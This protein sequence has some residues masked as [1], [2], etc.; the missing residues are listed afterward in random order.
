MK[1]VSEKCMHPNPIRGDVKIQLLAAVNHCKI[2]SFTKKKSQ[3]LKMFFLTQYQILII[4]GRLFKMLVHPYQQPF[5][6]ACKLS[7]HIFMSP[8]DRVKRFVPL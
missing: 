7:P 2:L 3:L 1:I 8:R 6:N 5:A 4:N